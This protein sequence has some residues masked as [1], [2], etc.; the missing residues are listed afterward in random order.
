MDIIIIIIMII[1]CS[2]IF[3]EVQWIVSFSI[4]LKSRKHAEKI[5]LNIELILL[6]K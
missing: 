1:Q 6:V 5:T 2:L 3:E 4:L